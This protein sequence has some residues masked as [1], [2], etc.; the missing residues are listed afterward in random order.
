MHAYTFIYTVTNL[1]RNFGYTFAD[2]STN[3]NLCIDSQIYW[4]IFTTTLHSGWNTHVQIEIYTQIPNNSLF[5][6]QLHFCFYWL[7]K[8]L[9]LFTFLFFNSE[10]KDK[11][12]FSLLLISLTH[13][14]LN[15]VSIVTE[16]NTIAVPK[17]LR[18]K[19]FLKNQV[20]L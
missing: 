1:I 19:G 5:K 16:T 7:T 17:T 13:T 20:S 10:P 6:I 3:S 4:P 2:S 15:R 14:L 8:H 12:W 11:I 9:L 18:Q